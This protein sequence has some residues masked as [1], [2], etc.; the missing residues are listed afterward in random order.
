M[1]YLMV[2]PVK[3]F[4]VSNGIVATEGAFRKHLSQLAD[5]LGSSLTGI[6]ITA[7]E[8][9]V[10]SYI[11]RKSYVAEIDEQKDRLNY[12]PLE[13]AIVGALTYWF[14][15]LPKIIPTIYAEVRSASVIHAG[16]SQLFYPREFLAILIGWLSKKKTIFV[17]DIDWRRS[18]W[19]NYKAGRWSLKGYR[20]SSAVYNPVLSL[21]V[22]FDRRF[23]SLVM[24]KSQKLVDDYGK[25]RANVKNILDT[26]YSAEHLIPD[27]VLAKKLAKLTEASRPIRLIYF[28]RLTGYKGVD[29]MITAIR[30]I[31]EQSGPAIS[32]TI[33]GLGED[34]L[35][36][37]QQ[38][39]EQQ[40][41]DMVT[42]V[43][44]MEYG[45]LLFTELLQFDLLLATPL[46]QDTPR[47]A[48]DAM[49]VGM[50]LL[51]YD[52]DYYKDLQTLSRAIK[53]VPWLDDQ[54]LAQAILHLNSNREELATMSSAG[55]QF[56]RQNT[57]EIWLAK[58]AEWTLKYCIANANQGSND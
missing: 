7:P 45:P 29:R 28:G 58:R 6:T 18:A 42:F 14:K 36:L 13:P 32:L 19:M 23:C 21:Q 50:P 41:Q 35:L 2:L 52:T 4:R 22:R 5:S 46:A 57:Q 53:V 10:D 51:A 48:L 39:K 38:V 1:K 26:A 37:K 25:G 8:M 49:A 33:M 56:A 20:L 15:Y 55:A 17:V 12:V 34:E 11:A 24:L 27:A 44:P 16:P 43:G 54:A 9:S 31:R 40:L 3:F 30:L 47:S